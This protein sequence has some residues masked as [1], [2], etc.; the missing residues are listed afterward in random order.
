MRAST[1]GWIVAGWSTLAP[2]AA[3]SAA[4]AKLSSGMGRASGT[5]RGSQVST[6]SKSVQIWTYTAPRAAP[7]SAAE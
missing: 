4:S 3:S 7:K 1:A 5:M 6:P 2:K